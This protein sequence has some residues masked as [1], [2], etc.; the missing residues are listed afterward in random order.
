M[1]TCSVCR[2]ENHP[3]TVICVR[4]G[5]YLQTRVDALDLFATAWDIV[6]R[7]FKAFHRIS[8]AQH[9]NYVYFL[10]SIAGIGFA[11]L[12]FWLMKAGEYSDS[13]INII[14]A[15]FVIG[16]PFGV[17]FSM[18]FSF[19]VWLTMKASRIE[20]SY[21]NIFAVSVY[22]FVPVVF[23]VVLILPIELMTF[24]TYFF[25]INP[26]PYTLKPASYIILLGLDGLLSL[27]SLLLLVI[28]MKILING[29]WT[30]SIFVVVVSGILLTVIAAALIIRF[31]PS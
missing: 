9:K 31:V 23:S 27:W 28:G 20:S 17:V 5:G 14:G 24:G 18:L 11:F 1:I 3:L 4:C 30:R 25:T 6:E 2:T 22:A 10:S 12:I 15:G 13:L 26:S 16:P 21:K 7:P 29:S 19:I 8:V